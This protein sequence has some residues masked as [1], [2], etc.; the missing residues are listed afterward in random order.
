MTLPPETPLWWY[1]LALGMASVLIGIAKSGFGGGFGL[2]AVP[3]VANALPVDRALGTWL[4]ILIFADLFAIWQHRH[5]RSW[6]H[7][8]W[9]CYGAVPGILVG[10]VVIWQFRQIG[11]LTVALN[12]VVGTVCILFVLLQCY[13]LLGGRVPSIGSGPTG[14]VGSG[15]VAGAVSTLA[16]SA[17]PVISIYLLEQRL[18]KHLL[19]GTMVSYFFLMNWAK[20]PSYIGLG[21]IQRQNLVEAMLWM[22]VV[23]LGSLLGMW[24][25]HR[26]RQRPFTL[27]MYL[28]AAI[29]GSRMIYKGVIEII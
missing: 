15:L 19:V 22:P 17:G 28:G 13:R 26:V 7:L 1:L 6:R 5:H 8:R 25:L 14:G 29:A 11:G 3:L 24:M 4:G 2:L 16:H 20:V 23:P 10:T 18:S 12:L 9:L 21:L 27:I